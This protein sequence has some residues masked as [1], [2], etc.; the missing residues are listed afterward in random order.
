MG[1]VNAVELSGVEKDRERTA[2]AIEDQFCSDCFDV[3]TQ[4][5]RARP[6]VDMTRKKTRK[7]RTCVTQVPLRVGWAQRGEARSSAQQ[8]RKLAAMRRSRAISGAI[9]NSGISVEEFV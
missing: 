1:T 4:M 5:G 6:N 2:A 3:G 7:E 9:L 8:S